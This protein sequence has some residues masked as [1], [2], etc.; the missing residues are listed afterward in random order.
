MEN[1]ISREEH[2]EFA[3]RMEDEHKR[4]NHRVADLEDTVRQIG[5]LTASVERLAQS[6]ESMAKSQSRQ[7]ARLEELKNLVMEEMKQN[8]QEI[9]RMIRYH[10]LLEVSYMKENII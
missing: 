5:E 8:L 7:E 9:P 4:I 3:R 2:E 10:G 6:V 1:G